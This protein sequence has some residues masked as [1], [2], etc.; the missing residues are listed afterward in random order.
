MNKEPPNQCVFIADALFLKGAKMNWTATLSLLSIIAFQTLSFGEGGSSAQGLKTGDK[1][2]EFIAEKEVRIGT[3]FGQYHMV[4][5]LGALPLGVT[6]LAKLRIVN[7]YAFDFPVDEL[8]LGCSCTSAEISADRIEA[9]SSVMLNVILS[10]RRASR[11]QLVV[12]SISMVSKSNKS[13]SITMAMRYTLAGLM[14]FNGDIFAQ[15]VDDMLERQTIMVP[16]LMTEPV[17]IDDVT[18]E[19]APDNKGVVVNL[20]REDQGYFAKITFDPVFVLGDS[21]ALSVIAH[22]HALGLSDTLPLVLYK[23]QNLEI[24]PLTLHFQRQDNQWTAACLLRYRPPLNTKLSSET[25]IGENNDAISAE[26]AIGGKK[27][28]V[29]TRR[30]GKGIYRVSLTSSEESLM[31]DDPATSANEQANRAEIRWHILTPDKAYAVESAFSAAS[32]PDVKR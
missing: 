5:D 1:Q 11:T 21:Y 16:F 23:R 28:D 9:K 8:E 29:R 20:V 25:F 6:G 12:N 31:P 24:S 13:K 4:V 30:I 26:A 15:E 27:L 2:M 7:P 14:R 17:K 10:T 22:N 32:F 3:V 19:L 18:F